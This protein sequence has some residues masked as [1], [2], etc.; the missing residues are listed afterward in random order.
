MI[1]I[2]APLYQSVTPSSVI[3]VFVAGGIS[4][5]PDW[6]RQF[7]DHFKYHGQVAFYNPRREDFDINNTDMSAEQIEWEYIHLNEAD[8]IVFWFPEETVCPIT[9]LELGKALGQKKDI[10]VG[11]H[12]NYERRFDVI[13]QI[14]MT[15]LDIPEVVDNIEDLVKLTKDAFDWIF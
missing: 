14:S 1:E 8:L 7:L 5:C 3:K 6:Q 13:H 4:K 10:V 15:G 9:L 12:P 11:T 2:V